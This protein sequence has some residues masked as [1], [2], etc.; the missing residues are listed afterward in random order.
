MGANLRRAPEPSSV[1]GV[2]EL[3]SAAI[4]QTTSRQAIALRRAERAMEAHARDYNRRRFGDL[5][6][7]RA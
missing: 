5:R 7:R 1:A 6:S 2:I 3:I 4:T